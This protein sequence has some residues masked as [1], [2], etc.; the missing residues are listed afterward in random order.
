MKRILIM[1]MAASPLFFSCKNEDTRVPA[2][3]SQKEILVSGSATGSYS[4]YS[5]ENG[6]LLPASDSATNKWDFAMRFA[7]I[8]VNSNASGPGSGGAKLLDGVFD[9]FTEAPADGYAYD[10]SAVKLAVKDDWYTY[11]PVTRS[12]APKAGKVFIFRT[13]AGKYA[14]LEMLT[15]DPTDDNGN[16]VVPPTRPTKIKYKFRTGYQRD[17]SRNF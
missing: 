14:K 10:T 3:V 13:G 2:E 5:F 16:A 12:F 1:M 7:T 4:F 15:A 11:N 17:G 6:A 8:I 9:S